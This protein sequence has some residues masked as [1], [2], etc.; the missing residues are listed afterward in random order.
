MAIRSLVI[1]CALL[2]VAVANGGF[3][4]AVLIPRVGPQAG[5]AVSTMLLCAGIFVVTYFAVP[6]IRPATPRQAVAVGLAWLVLTLAFEFGFGHYLRR[7]PWQELLVDYNVLKGRIWVLV[8]LTTALAPLVTGRV[9]GL[10][11]PHSAP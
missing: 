1:W 3:R 9:R 2:A 4:E 10:F 7:R 8:L 5:H 6:W 11:G